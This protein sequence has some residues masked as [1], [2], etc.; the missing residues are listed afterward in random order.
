M[1]NLIKN[2]TNFC[3]WIVKK[4]KVKINKIKFRKKLRLF[5][6]YYRIKEKSLMLFVVKINLNQI[7]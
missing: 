1:K 3:W 7:N 4:N 2:K 5:K 6:K